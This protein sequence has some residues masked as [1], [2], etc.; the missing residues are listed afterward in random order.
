MLLDLLRNH[1]ND[2]ARKFNSL[3]QKE[4]KREKG[5]LII[6]KDILND[7]GE[8]KS[9]LSKAIDSK[10]PQ[11]IE[12]AIKG[13]EGNKQLINLFSEIYKEKDKLK[14]NMELV[15]EE[16][17]EEMGLLIDIT[18]KHDDDDIKKV[19]ENL[20]EEG[21]ELHS[22]MKQQE[23]VLDN[24]L[25]QIKSQLDPE[26]GDA[27][28]NLAHAQREK[29]VLRNID[30]VRNWVEKVNNSIAAIF[31]I[32]DDDNQKIAKVIEKVSKQVQAA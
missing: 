9:K 19:Y 26:H 4:G 8:M 11:K 12:E 21:R 28:K 22:L 31:N 7:I 25:G 24:S 6:E 13:N 10:N 15:M 14:R 20:K 5:V 18:R 17:K 30:D 29:E 23:G 32:I 1:N 2:I 3:K 16:Y 27:V